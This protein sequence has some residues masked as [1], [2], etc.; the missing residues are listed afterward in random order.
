MTDKLND[1]TQMTPDEERFWERVEAMDATS[2]FDFDT[3]NNK[4]AESYQSVIDAGDVHK[5]ETP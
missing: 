1:P 4:I 5:K 3:P 2:T